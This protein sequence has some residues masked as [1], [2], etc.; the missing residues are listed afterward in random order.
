MNR[1]L[2]IGN[3]SLESQES[4]LEELFSRAGSVH[5]V[6]IVSDPSTG[7]K[8][9]FAFVEMANSAEAAR[10]RELFDGAD[11]DGRRIIVNTLTR[12]SSSTLISRI[13]RLLRP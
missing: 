10:A 4:E 8:K 5:S 1:R 9:G 3:L 13:V 6:E 11:I 2:L 12:K 7:K